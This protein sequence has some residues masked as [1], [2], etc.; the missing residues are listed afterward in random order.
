VALQEQPI[1]VMQVVIQDQEMLVAVAV[2]AQLVLTLL[3]MAVLV[4]LV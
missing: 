2:L 4:V 1:K 3:L